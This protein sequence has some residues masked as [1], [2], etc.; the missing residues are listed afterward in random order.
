MAK[1]N[2]SSAMRAELDAVV[3]RYEALVC[4]HL[5]TLSALRQEADSELRHKLSALSA[6]NEH[7]KA[8]V[9]S[10]EAE[11]AELALR[12]AELVESAERLEQ[13]LQAERD[14]A[15]QL[16]EE[17]KAAGEQAKALQ[18]T[19]AAEIRFIEACKG[20]EGTLLLEALAGALEGKAELLAKPETY[21]VLKQKGL[22][23][24]L[25]MAFRERGRKAA[26]A[27]LLAREQAALPAL[28]GA[29][30]CELLIPKTGE[31]FSPASMEKIKTVSEPSEEGNVLDCAMPGLRLVGGEGSLVLPKVVVASG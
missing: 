9:A 7:Y 20:L 24:L 17:V 5:E 6:E 31:R 12:V 4:A 18:S 28:S 26:S 1:E 14:R 10:L 2:F 16:D 15:A 13:E 22:D 30:D 29:A 27:P 11:K 8:Q 21:G 19:F 23:S 25:S 3:A